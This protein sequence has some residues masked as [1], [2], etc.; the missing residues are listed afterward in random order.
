MAREFDDVIR[1]DK[2]PKAVQQILFLIR[3]HIRSSSSG[4]SVLIGGTGQIV[5]RGHIFLS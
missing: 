5:G 4:E 3:A 1:Y 2:G